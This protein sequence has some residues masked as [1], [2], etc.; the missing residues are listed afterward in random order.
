MVKNE[1]HTNHVHRSLAPSC[2]CCL[3]DEHSFVFMSQQIMGAA[4]ASWLGHLEESRERG[5][6]ER[7]LL[8]RRN[9]ALPLIVF[10]AH[11]GRYKFSLPHDARDIV[12]ISSASFDD[13]LCF[14]RRALGVCGRRLRWAGSPPSFSSRARRRTL[15][16]NTRGH[17]RQRTW[18]SSSWKT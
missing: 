10:W 15:P 18:P 5:K 16:C 3:Y 9:L 8:F 6:L 17:A 14:L 4:C 12:A 2:L 1:K 11:T 7:N 13:L